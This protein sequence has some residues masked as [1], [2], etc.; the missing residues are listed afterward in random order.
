MKRRVSTG[1]EGNQAKSGD[2]G[3][4]L[5]HRMT[6][7]QNCQVRLTARDK[8]CVCFPVCVHVVFPIFQLKRAL[9]NFPQLCIEIF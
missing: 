6:H 1:L 4:M 9:C 3:L 2:L 5:L 7:A 8:K